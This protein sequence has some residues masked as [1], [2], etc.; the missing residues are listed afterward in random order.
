MRKIELQE[1]A[2]LAKS[3][4]GGIDRIYLHWTAGH[5]NTL[6]LDYHL[7]ITGDGDL[8]LSTPDLRTVL[9]HTWMRNTGALGLALCCCADAK[10][11]PDG[12]FNLGTEAPTCWQIEVC[13]RTIA[14]LCDVLEVAIDR[15]HVLTHAEIGDIDG[16]GPAFLGTHQFEKWDLWYLRDYDEAWRSG[17]DV[18]RGKANWY[19]GT[20]QPL[21]I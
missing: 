19:L 1:L 21:V 3:A 13:A 10:I 16:Y 12:S 14:L 17:G 5:Y 20:P 9:A 11:Y 2:Q 4:K 18:L 6:C 15:E 8:Y 7:N